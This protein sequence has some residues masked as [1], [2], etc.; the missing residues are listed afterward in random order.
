MISAKIGTR[1]VDEQVNLPTR[2]LPVATITRRLEEPGD[3]TS[4]GSVSPFGGS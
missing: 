1:L 4:I 2:Q 3:E